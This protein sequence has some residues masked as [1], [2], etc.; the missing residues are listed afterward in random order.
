MKPI[1]GLAV[2]RPISTLMCFLAVLIFGVIAASDLG[3][4]FLPEIE[5]P[6]LVVTAAYP[7]LPRTR[8]PRSRASVRFSPYRARGSAPWSST[9]TGART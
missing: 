2:K 9:F 3:V 5:V 6:K 4:E 7:G 8:F 1:I